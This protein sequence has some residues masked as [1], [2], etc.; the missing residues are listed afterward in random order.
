MKN[1]LLEM[2]VEELKLFAAEM[3]EKPF[4]GKQLFKWIHSGVKD[5]DYMTNLSEAFRRK[6]SEKA[7]ITGVEI[8]GEQRDR[9]DGTRKFLYRLADGETVEG[10]FMKYKYGNSLC[11]SSQVGCRMGCRF[12][13]STADGLIRNLTAGEML[14]QVYESEKYTGEK[15]NHIVVMGMGEPFDNYENLARFLRLLHDP[16]GKNLSYRNMTV[17]TCGIV[18][19]MKRSSEDFA[20]VNLAVSLH[21]LTDKGRSEIMPVNRSYPLEKLLKACREYTENTG[22][23]IT[24]EYAL[25]SGVNDGARDVEL[26]KEKLGGMLC[27]V[28]LI[29]LNKVEEN[30]FRGTGRKRA[31]DIA[32]QLEKSGVPATVRRELG[33]EIDGACGQLRRK[34]DLH[35]AP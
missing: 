24:F 15:I 21:R 12:C 9:S 14:D 20:S 18:P 17:S 1:N 19:A 28:N 7:E 11:L 22:R 23:R 30:N 29:P 32:L 33:A 27:H 16:E 2:T 4:R 3:G 34:S 35:I 13:A 10:V 25:I 5:F 8:I 6:L 31:A 26:I